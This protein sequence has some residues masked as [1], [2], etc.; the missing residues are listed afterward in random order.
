MI[1]TLILTGCGGS[2]NSSDSPSF[3][4][5]P[6]STMYALDSFSGEYDFLSMLVFSALYVNAKEYSIDSNKNIIIKYSQKPVFKTEALQNVVTLESVSTI[7]PP[8]LGD[9]QHLIG[10]KAQFDGENLKYTVSNYAATKALTVSWKYKRIDV[11]G[12]PI[13]SD[14]NNP[15]HTIE[16]SSNAEILAAIWG[17][18]YAA[19]NDLFPEGSICWQKQSAQNN[20]EYIEFYPEKIMRHVSEDSEVDRSGQW[21]KA[22]W[23]QFKKDINSP[24]RANVKL[25]IDNKIYWG[26]YHPL[27]ES[28]INSSDQLTCDY[29]NEKAFNAVMPTFDSLL[30]FLQGDNAEG[31]GYYDFGQFYSAD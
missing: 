5:Q 28:F 16:K 26:F 14:Q 8:Q 3:S 31:E 22:S 30:K 13:M 12:K 21:N 10:E 11:S 17:M 6:P 15:M 2:D 20:Q 19:P 24:E 18:G 25:I 7:M 9:F 29:M 23:T 4:Y 1:S 27:N